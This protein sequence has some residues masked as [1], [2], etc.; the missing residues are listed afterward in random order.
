[1]V[2]AGNDF[3]ELK[4]KDPLVDEARKPGYV[5]SFFLYGIEIVVDFGCEVCLLEIISTFDFVSAYIV[6]H[7]CHIFN[8]CMIQVSSTWSK[9][10]L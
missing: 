7:I 9:W 4:K 2:C 6:S 1:M 8:D 10:G 3:A 5:R